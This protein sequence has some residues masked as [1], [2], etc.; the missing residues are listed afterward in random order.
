MHVLINVKKIPQFHLVTCLGNVPFGSE[1]D[2]EGSVSETRTGIFK[3]ELTP[4]TR[5][6]LA[7]NG[8][9]QV[10]GTC[11][12]QKQQWKLI[13]EGSVSTVLLFT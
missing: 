12:V 9:R 10:G 5:S 8:T 11:S 6:F 7:F 1:T 2:F 13:T 3:F 4:V